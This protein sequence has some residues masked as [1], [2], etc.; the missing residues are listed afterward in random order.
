METISSLVLTFL[1]NAL[2][3]ITLVAGIAAFGAWLLRNNAASERFRHLL[4]VAALSLSVLLPSLSLLNIGST[5]IRSLP[6]LSRV[7]EAMTARAEINSMIDATA[8][9]AN[10][11][12]WLAAFFRHTT[13]RSAPFGL[14]LLA[15]L[16]TICYMLFLLYRVLWLGSIWRRTSFIRNSAREEMAMPEMNSMAMRCREALHLRE[17]TILYSPQVIAPLTLGARHPVIVLP[18][19]FLEESSEEML[20]SVLGHEMAH[21]RRGDFALNLLYELLLLPISFHP[22]AA[23]MKRYINRTR[24]LICD[25]MVAESVVDSTVYARSL[26]RLADSV[27][28]SRPAYTLGVFDADILEE[29][30]MRLI[31]RKK[32]K[33]ARDGKAL[34]FALAF[35]LTA[36]GIAASAFSFHVGHLVKATVSNKDSAIVG[37]WHANWPQHTELPAL[38]LTMNSDAG[39]LSGTIVFYWMLYKE[40]GQPVTGQVESPLIEPKFDGTTLSF[41]TKNKRADDN[42][43]KA[44]SMKLVS[45]NELQL[46]SDDSKQIFHLMKSEKSA[47]STTVSLQSIQTN[48]VPASAAQNSIVGDWNLRAYGGANNGEAAAE[49]P[50]LV[51][52]IKTDGDKLIGTAISWKEAEPKQGWQKVEW[53]LIE[54]KFD[55]HT[56]TFKV[57]NGEEILAGEL[58]LVG[59]KF[60]G[61]WNS[62]KSKQ[63]GKLK[64]TRRD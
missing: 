21:I 47:T 32:F 10:S 26:I 39:K 50:G 1:L 59:D 27:L 64:L 34:A 9:T 54:P 23:L 43:E 8:S 11:A 16:L 41:R 38:D 61:R 31:E 58:T 35:L 45:E 29:R 51:L 7:T 52:K 57:S 4:W 42:Q 56:F 15:S 2:W 24:E 55:G 49:G 20:A 62:S 36:T 19:N 3:Q 37:V 22:A 18:L 12:S 60:E 13:P 44:F 33:G 28:L 6:L 14:P 40:G 17:A 5:S 25:E 63:S 48:S 53:P 46:L 30:I